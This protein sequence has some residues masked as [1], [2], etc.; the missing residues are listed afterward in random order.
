MVV[1]ASGVDSNFMR[2]W[3]LNENDYYSHVVM[4]MA[5]WLGAEGMFED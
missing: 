3:P 2:L 1:S 4:N 5:T